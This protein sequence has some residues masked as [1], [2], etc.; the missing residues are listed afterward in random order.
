MLKS[1]RTLTAITR[2]CTAFAANKVA[3]IVALGLLYMLN[4]ITNFSI[5]SHV[6][7][8]LIAGHKCAGEI[9]FYCII[10]VVFMYVC[11]NF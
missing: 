8:L 5:F 4:M 1:K 9:F 6:V 11:Y 2:R 7:G 3:Q 10:C